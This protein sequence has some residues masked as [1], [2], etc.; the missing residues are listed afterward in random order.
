MQVVEIAKWLTLFYFVVS[1]LFF[2]VH[3]LL[4]FP[5]SVRWFKRIGMNWGISSLLFSAM[6]MLSSIISDV[7]TQ[8]LIILGGIRIVASVI[9]IIAIGMVNLQPE[10]PLADEDK[11]ADTADG[12]DDTYSEL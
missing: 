10:S 2:A 5:E 11:G 1:T 7:L 12:S 4:G 8:K 9:V 6:D 3:I